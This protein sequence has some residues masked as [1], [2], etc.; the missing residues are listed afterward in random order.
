MELVRRYT[1]VKVWCEEIEVELLGMAKWAQRPFIK[2][3]SARKV[4][5]R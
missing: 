2:I 3:R 4:A 5:L 1:T